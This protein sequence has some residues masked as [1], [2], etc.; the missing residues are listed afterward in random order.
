MERGF[1]ARGA[2]SRFAGGRCARGEVHCAW[3]EVP[4]RGG[5]LRA[6]RGPL[7]VERWAASR[8][9][10]ARGAR[11]TARGARS[12][13]AGGRCARGVQRASA[14]GEGS[15][16]SL[17]PSPKVGDALRPAHVLARCT[18][19]WSPRARVR[20]A[21]SLSETPPTFGEGLVVAGVSPDWGGYGE[22][23]LGEPANARTL[24]RLRVRERSHRMPDAPRAVDAAPRRGGTGLG[25]QAA[26]RCRSTPHAKCPSQCL[27]CTPRAARS[28]A[29]ARRS[30]T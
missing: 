22:E 8:G 13:F 24:G 4:L 30:S 11:S 18:F 29:R 23:V 27:G 9:A 28:S 10:A 21:G 25:S 19:A 20:A 16:R 6:G 15:V 5:P 14:G 2:R 1:A 17:R 12:R 3:S 26:I 7:R